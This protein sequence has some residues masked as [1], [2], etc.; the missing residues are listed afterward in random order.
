MGADPAKGLTVIIWANVAPNTEG[1]SPA[2]QLAG[3]VVP[4]LLTGDAG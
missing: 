4:L 3:T 2:D 1:K